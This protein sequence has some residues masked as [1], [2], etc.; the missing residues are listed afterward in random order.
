MIENLKPLY[1]RILRP[2]AI[3]LHKI[4]LTPNSVTI[5][6]ILFFF[7]GAWLTAIGSWKIAVISYIVG[8]CMDGLDG[9]LAR[10]TGQK[11]IFGGILDSVSD[12]V[13]EILWVG[14]IIVFYTMQP[15]IDRYGIL[16]GYAALTGSMLVS[17]VKARAEGEKIS[18]SSGIMQRPE[19]LIALAI[20]QLTGS[21]VVMKYGLVCIAIITYLTVFQRL[22][23]VYKKTKGKE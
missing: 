14:G 15:A 21:P 23:I 12:R 11:T 4:G 13:T 6:G 20:L 8:S 19:R 1:N 22:W 9:V 17:Y 2:G 3:V 16:G 10:E 18:C 7:L 5:L